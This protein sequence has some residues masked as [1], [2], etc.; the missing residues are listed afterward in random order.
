MKAN[1][2]FGSTTQPLSDT[3]AALDIGANT[4]TLTNYGPG[5]EYGYC[6]ATSRS[7]SRFVRQHLT[8]ARTPP[9]HQFFINVSLNA[10]SLANYSFEWNGTNYSHYNPSLVLML[11]LDN[12]SAVGDSSTTAWM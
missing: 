5:S 9:R 12:N 6:R 7:A 11:N 3:G 10:S 2:G 4:L 1:S 8:T